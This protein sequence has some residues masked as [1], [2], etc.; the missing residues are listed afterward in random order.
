MS[1]QHSLHKEAWLIM[2]L[3]FIYA[4]FKIYCYDKLLK[5]LLTFMNLKGK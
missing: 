4:E 5:I 1:I 2:C 3:T